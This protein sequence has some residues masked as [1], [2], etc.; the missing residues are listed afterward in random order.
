MLLTQALGEAVLL[1]GAAALAMYWLEDARRPRPRPA[2]VLW[3]QRP[4][5]ELQ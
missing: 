3:L 2:A 4:P 1:A 5:P